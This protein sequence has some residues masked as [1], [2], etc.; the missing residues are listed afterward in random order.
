M[1][2]S[3]TPFLKTLSAPLGVIVNLVQAPRL[4][5]LKTETLKEKIKP[6]SL[7]FALHFSKG[8]PVL[9]FYKNYGRQN[10]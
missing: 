1:E 5:S 7:S 2:A 6:L 3:A 9:S 4:I 10:S 8:L